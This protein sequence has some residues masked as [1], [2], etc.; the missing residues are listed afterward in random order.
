[1]DQYTDETKVVL[2]ERFDET[3]DGIY[4]SH[5]PIYGYRSKYSAESNISRHMIT[6]SILNT[7]NKYSFDS[8]IDIGGAEGYTAFLVKNLFHAQVTSTDLSE[9]ACKRANEIFGIEAVACDI[10]SLPFTDHQFDA[11]LCSETI[12]HVTDFKKAVRELLRITKD[13]LVITIPHDSPEEV[14][15]NI[16][17]KVPHGHINHFDLTAFDYLKAEGYSIKAE[18]SQSPF[19]VVPRVIAEGT[20][21]ENSGLPYKVYNSLTPI[22]RKVFGI[23]TA[24]K[25]IDIDQKFCSIFKKYMGITFTIEKNSASFKS[26]EPKPV[27]A[28]DFVYERVDYYRPKK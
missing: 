25:L 14:E 22:L 15:A 21:K 27:T 5:Q 6:R 23:K 20:P 7:L 4:Y 16:R 24:I 18:K 17:N 9:S 1:M 19:L 11:V 10:H 12:E 8:F 3:I 28:K 2:D 13:V 26:P